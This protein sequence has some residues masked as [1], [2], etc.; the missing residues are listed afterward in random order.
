MYSY[1]IKVQTVISKST[2]CAGEMASII[3]LY[4]FILLDYY[5]VCI[6]M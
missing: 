5:Y 1:D 6:N 3:T 2:N 4:C